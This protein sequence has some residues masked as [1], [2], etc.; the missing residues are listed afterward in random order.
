[1]YPRG[2]YNDHQ[3]IVRSI[4]QIYLLVHQPFDLLAIELVM[5]LNEVF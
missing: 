4:V 1:M 2:N 5:S 3:Q